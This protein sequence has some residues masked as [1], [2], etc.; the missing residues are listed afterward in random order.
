L[1]WRDFAWAEL[2]R[3]WSTY[4]V[5]GLL[6]AGL[7]G[8]SIRAD[9]VSRQQGTPTIATITALYIPATDERWRPGSIRVL[10]RTPARVIGE[11]RVSS[12]E[13]R[14]CRVGDRVPAAQVG[15][16]LRLEPRPCA[17]ARK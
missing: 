12:R 6:L 15:P 13:I 2:R 11:T 5:I 4:L 9:I 10:A 3:G 1:T 8:L 16:W 7:V 14:G 17:D